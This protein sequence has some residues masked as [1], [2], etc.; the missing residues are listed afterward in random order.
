MRHRFSRRTFMAK[1]AA[2]TAAVAGSGASPLAEGHGAPGI[3]NPPPEVSA[4]R[5]RRDLL[6]VNGR[7]HT[8]DARDTVARAVMIRDGRVTAVGDSPAAD[9]SPAVEV[10][11]PSRPHRGSRSDRDTPARARYGRS[12]GVSRDRRRERS[13]IR[14]FRKRSPVIAR[15]CSKVNG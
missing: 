6:L 3:Q 13:S 2:A 14:E 1:A 4:N 12:A 7:I 8:L 5:P 10:I 15:R 11:R 9:L